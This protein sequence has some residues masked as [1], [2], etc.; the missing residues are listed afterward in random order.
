M[1]EKINKIYEEIDPKVFWIP[2]HSVCS[3]RV[4]HY[5]IAVNY[6]EK[7]EFFYQEEHII[8]LSEKWKNKKE[9]IEHPSNIEAVEFIYNH[10]L[11]I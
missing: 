7:G 11:S 4:L 8:E 2:W 10:F 6:I 1:K 3:H 5:G 9:S